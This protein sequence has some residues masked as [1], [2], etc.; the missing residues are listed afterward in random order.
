[1]LWLLLIYEA[2]AGFGKE[3]VRKLNHT[4]LVLVYL[5]YAKRLSL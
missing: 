3:I 5:P 2:A 4:A 1:M